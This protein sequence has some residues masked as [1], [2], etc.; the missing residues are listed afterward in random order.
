MWHSLGTG[1]ARALSACLRRARPHC[2][3][4][5]PGVLEQQGEEEPSDKSAAGREGAGL[6]GP[7]Q[8]SDTAPR[9]CARLSAAAGGADLPVRLRV[10]GGHLQ[11]PL[12]AD[13]RHPHLHAALTAPGLHPGA[14][15][16]AK[17]ISR[18]PRR[19]PQLPPGRRGRRKGGGRRS[20]TARYSGRQG[21]ARLKRTPAQG[22]RAHPH[23]IPQTRVH[24]HRVPQ[25]RAHGHRVPRTRVTGTESASVLLQTC[26]FGNLGEVPAHQCSGWSCV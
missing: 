20:R 26:K 2:M 10:P 8:L 9:P 19:D 24:G 11:H 6:P 13:P 18:G 14:G 21:G 25:T 17:M 5:P 12:P 15:F 23:R 3:A 1:R 4:R 22:S 7:P 16:Q